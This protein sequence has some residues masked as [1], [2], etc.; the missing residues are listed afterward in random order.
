MH[1]VIEG[2][3]SLRRS[4][5]PHC[6]MVSA[7]SRQCEEEEVGEERGGEWSREGFARI[8]KSPPKSEISTGK[9]EGRDCR[10]VALSPATA[11]TYIEPQVIEE[12]PGLLLP[13]PHS[14]IAREKEAFL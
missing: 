12:D 11:G 10:K 14:Q 8:L 3:C 4:E 7:R 9:A 2:D 13:G 1:C 6:N 5:K